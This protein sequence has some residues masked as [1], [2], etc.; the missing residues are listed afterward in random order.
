MHKETL[1]LKHRTEVTRQERYRG[2]KFVM[3]SNNVDERILKLW[4]LDNLLLKR[5]KQL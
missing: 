1:S 5:E 4:W 3:G 2:S